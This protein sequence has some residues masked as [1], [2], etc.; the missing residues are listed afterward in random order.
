MSVSICGGLKFGGG[1]ELI[2]GGLRYLRLSYDC[3][4]MHDMWIVEDNWKQAA[5]QNAE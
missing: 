1:G 5:N 3:V 2:V 4:L